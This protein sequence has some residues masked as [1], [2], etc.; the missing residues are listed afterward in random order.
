MTTGNK[1]LVID[2]DKVKRL[3]KNI[4]VE[5]NLGGRKNASIY[6]NGREKR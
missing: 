4:Q 5:E 1:N 6:F 2:K 3:G